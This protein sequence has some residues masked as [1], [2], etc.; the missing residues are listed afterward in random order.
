MW[1]VLIK[2]GNFKIY[3]YGV[4]V[5]LG[6]WISYTF[7]RNLAKKEG[8]D[9]KIVESLAIWSIF[10]G[11][12]GGRILFILINF[13]DFW[14]SP[15]TYIFSRAGFAFQGGILL[16]I[17]GLYIMCKKK[18]LNFLQFVDI[19][20]I[21]VVLGHSIGRI[22]CF[23]NGCCYGKP[24]EKFGI[25]F[26]PNSPAGVLGIKVIPT[27]LISSFFLF[28]IFLM[29][30]RIYKKRRFLGQVFFSYFLFYGFFRFFIEFLRGDPR[31]FLGILSIFQ[32]ISIV[33]FLIGVVGILSSVTGA[34]KFFKKE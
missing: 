25:L 32:Y 26:H 27:Q 15:F 31:P 23:L 33:F 7:I 29:L 14:A 9:L 3:S 11:L 17:I 28:I 1:P 21:G 24:S 30:L 6:V 18:K 10:L 13:K 2:I 12:L 22:G 5:F 16:G 4:L 19:F 34:D 8:L 20:S